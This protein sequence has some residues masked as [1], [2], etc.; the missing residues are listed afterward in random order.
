[1][2][3]IIANLV[4][5]A[6]IKHDADAESVALLGGRLVVSASGFVV[7]R[8]AVFTYEQV[9]FVQLLQTLVYLLAVEGGWH[10]NSLPSG[11][12][13]MGYRYSLQHRYGLSVLLVLGE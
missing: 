11:I 4:D 10:A 3:L 5:L 12:S 8:N 2:E 7:V 13:C 6:V 1:M 9:P